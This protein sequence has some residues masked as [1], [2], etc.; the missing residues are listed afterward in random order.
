MAS[1]LR[2][3]TL[4]ACLLLAIAAL[5]DDRGVFSGAVTGAQAAPLCDGRRAPESVSLDGAERA[6]LRGVVQAPLAG[7]AASRYEQGS[8]GTANLW[9]DDQ[10][11]QTGRAGG[12]EAR[13]WALDADGR[14]DD[15]VI[16]ALRYHSAADASRTLALATDPGCRHGGEAQPVAVPAGARTLGWVNPDGAYQ[17]DTL[18]VRGALLYR[19]S[20]VPPSAGTGAAARGHDG[21]LRL[22]A[23][24]TTRALACALPAAGCGAAAIAAFVA[25]AGPPAR[26]IAE[27][28]SGWPSTRAEAGAFLRAVAIHPYDVQ[29][30][31]QVRGATSSAGDAGGPP[32]CVANIAGL[33]RGPS[34]TSAVFAYRRRLASD[35]VISRGWILPSQTAATRFV[36]SYA[37]ALRNGCLE[38]DFQASIGKPRTS[39]TRATVA[40]VHLSA[41]PA[42]APSIYVWHAPYRAAAL[43]IAVKIVLPRKAGRPLR[44]PYFDE[45]FLFAYRRAVI[46]FTAETT[47]EPLPEAD[48]RYLASVLVGRAQAGW[49]R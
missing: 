12:F 48:R 8:V 30:M 32:P 39:R 23:R 35:T 40:D 24:A 10:P 3:G 49:G 44:I 27:A 13:W 33:H 5:L 7:R 9:T 22:R 17:R 18:F 37:A 34:A 15:V 11:L 42:P 36:A 29:W 2:V 1:S 6:R 20:D 4:V 47:L 45:G 26:P 31:R 19:I 38:R 21:L 25:A 16:D 28:P 43:R 14:G 46:A 41:L